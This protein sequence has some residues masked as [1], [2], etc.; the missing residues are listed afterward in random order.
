[1]LSF[2]CSFSQLLVLV[3]QVSHKN[4]F[5]HQ[6]GFTQVNHTVRSTHCYRLSSTRIFAVSYD[7]L[8]K[9]GRKLHEF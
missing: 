4:E 7:Q 3:T 6:I 1:M 5:Q 8:T 2:S 9:C